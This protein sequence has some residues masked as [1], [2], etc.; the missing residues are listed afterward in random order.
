MQFLLTQ[1]EFSNL[2]KREEVE[3]R[4]YALDKMRVLLLSAKGF[5]CIHD[6]KRMDGHRGYCDEC[7]VADI[8]EACSKPKNWSK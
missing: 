4:D 5:V 2:V 1:E 8:R 3:K 7:P 6:K